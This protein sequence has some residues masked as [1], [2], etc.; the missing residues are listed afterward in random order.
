M[1]SRILG[2]LIISSAVALLFSALPADL[3]GLKLAGLGATLSAAT[4]CLFYWLAGGGTLFVISR[5][6]IALLPVGLIAFFLTSIISRGEDPTENRIMIAA[7][8][9]SGGWVVGLIT[10]ELRR[11]DERDEKRRDL[12]KALTAEIQAII[13][14]NRKF[15]WQDAVTKAKHDFAED[16]DFLPF[17]VYLHETDVLRR[18]V[19]E[20]DLLHRDQIREVYAF[21]HLMDKIRQIAVR[22]DGETYRLL[23]AERRLDVYT[24]LLKMH[25]AV[26][27]T[28]ETALE[29][30]KKQRFS[31]VIRWSE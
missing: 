12:I 16:Q 14:L 28:G 2:I 27:E 10:Q 22:L 3:G 17:L 23:A 5:A 9:V 20:I 11:F 26:V 15:D 25:G 19:N 18:V 8:V 31:G 13:D 7:V 1:H 6:I 4:A 24:R 30:L 21:F 29:A